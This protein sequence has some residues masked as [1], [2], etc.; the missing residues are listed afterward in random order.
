MTVTFDEVKRLAAR[1]TTNEKARLIDELADEIQQEPPSLPDAWQ[2]LFALSADFRA[3]H[4]QAD[5]TAQ[6][7]A[8]RNERQRLLERC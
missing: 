4:P 7:E 2:R 1:L 6:L 3:A 5:V 8:D